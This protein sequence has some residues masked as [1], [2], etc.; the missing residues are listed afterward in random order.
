M[1]DFSVIVPAYNNKQKIERAIKSVLNQTI[2]NWELIIVDDGST[3]AT[4]EVV[5]S[6]LKDSRIKYVKQENQGVTVA[7]NTGV[8]NAVGEFFTFLDSDDEVEANWL[9]DF[10]DLKKSGTAYISCGY[11]MEGKKYFPKVKQNISEIKY[12]SLAGTFALKKSVYNSIGG[13]DFNLKQSENYE[14]TARAIEFCESHG[15]EVVS[16]DNCNFIYHHS[17]T[18]EQTLERDRLRAEASLYLH[19]KY[20]KGGVLHFRKDSYLKSAAVNFIRVGEFKKGRK[21]LVD[22]LKNKPSMKSFLDILVIQVPF[23]RKRIWM[24]KQ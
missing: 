23:L 6:Y 14:M 4:H 24:R 15:L 22:I 2:S 7:R 18:A 19:Q 16:T 17:K 13:Y 12:S 11:V 8:Q 20:N 5:H 9:Q 21:I 3:D 1:I 10:N